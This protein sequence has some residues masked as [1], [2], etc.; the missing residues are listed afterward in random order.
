MKINNKKVLIAT[1]NKG[2][3]AEFQ[4][5]FKKYGMQTL[6][7]LD[8]PDIED[9]EETGETFEENARLKAE[10]ISSLLHVPVLADDSGIMIDALDGRPGVFSARYAG[11]AKNDQDNNDKVLDELKSIPMESRTARFVCVL[12][13]A[14]P[15]KETFFVTGSCE[16][17]IALSASGS[18]G[19]GY[20]PIFIPEG[21]SKTMAE[22]SPEEK[23]EISHRGRAINELDKQLKNIN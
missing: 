6:S 21:Y 19:F 18:N 23:N 8:F 1:K 12:A 15:N 11:L 3:I 17:K 16:G 2:K 5:L 9:V 10:E 14:R 4:A 13:V 20:D 7:L 22:I